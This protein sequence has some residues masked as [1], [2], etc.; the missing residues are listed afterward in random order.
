MIAR[1]G[2]MVLLM[3]L[4][5]SPAW[6]GGFEVNENAANI[7]AR[8][9]AFTAKADNPM[10]IHYNPAGLLNWQGHLFYVG[11]NM[12]ILNLEFERAGIDAL[13]ADGTYSSATVS[14]E[15]DPFFAPSLAWGYGGENW[16]VGAAVYG[17]GAVGNRSFDAEGPQRF[18]MTEEN[19]LLGYASLAGAYQLTPELSLGVT[20]QFVTMPFAQL[21]M[22]IDANYTAGKNQDE[23]DPWLGQAEVDMADWTG[24]TS[25]VGL[26]YKPTSFFEMGISSRVLPIDIHATGNLNLSFPNPDTQKLL[27]NGS[28]KTVDASCDKAKDCPET[29]EGE[30]SLVLPPWVRLGLRYVDRDESGKELFDIEIDFVY[31][32]WSM[33]D[34]YRVNTNYQMSFLGQ[35]IPISEIEMKKDY[36]DSWS[37]RVGSDVRLVEDLVWLHL[38]AHYESPAVTKAYTHLDFTNFHRIGGSLG[39]TVS[40]SGVELTLAYQ[41]IYQP[42]WVVSADEAQM[43]L[44]RPTSEVDEQIIVN[45]GSYR[46]QY[47]TLSLGLV[48]S[49]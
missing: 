49:F 38:G 40:L 19:F 39:A 43:P 15:A 22:I 6:S 1:V 8:S 48:A 28:L 5:A 9:G 25:I 11:S 13:V 32:F 35:L 16:A 20:A 18:L 30:L 12:N 17:P 4:A 34:A 29:T 23:T 21:T 2:W 37:V 26:H 27:D 46:S 31:E 3:S 33:L 10:A 45:E 41:F 44:L 14:N 42:E 7:L 24:F 36:Q 47:H